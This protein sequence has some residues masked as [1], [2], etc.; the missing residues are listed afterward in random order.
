M[1]TPS[2]RWSLALAAVL[3]ELNQGFHH[4]LG[5][6]G[7]GEHT[8]G[9][10]RNALATFWGITDEASF[11]ATL[12]WLWS[13]G[14]SAEVLKIAATLGPD[15]RK[16]DERA[17]LV[18]ANRALLDGK[19]LLAWD[20]GRF[21]AVVGWGRWAGFVPEAEAWQLLHGAA[22][23]VQRSFKSWREFGRHY[24][25]GRYYWSNEDD[26]RCEAILAKLTSDPTS[27]WMQLDWKL[28]LGPTPG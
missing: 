10:C 23:R 15:P 9:W 24:E 4:E 11:R 5:G 6:W 22:A 20:L 19:G 2:Q 25:F 3:T 16:D 17:A 21:V 8:E 28:P 27:P 14:H 18:R 1:A 7:E 26:P 12:T 13:E